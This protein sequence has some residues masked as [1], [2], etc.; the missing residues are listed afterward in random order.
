MNVLLKAVLLSPG[1]NC[2]AD[3][4]EQSSIRQ[5]SAPTKGGKKTALLVCFLFASSPVLF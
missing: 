3:I 1:T 2:I 5:L 4:Y